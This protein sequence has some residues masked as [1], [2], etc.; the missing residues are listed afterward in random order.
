MKININNT[1][2]GT[3]NNIINSTPKL[4]NAI[5]IGDISRKRLVLNE[6]TISG[7]A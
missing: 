7:G 6:V 2:N 4:I 3:I 1:I 5:V